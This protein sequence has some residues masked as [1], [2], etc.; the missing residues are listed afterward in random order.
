MIYTGVDG[1]KS[2]SVDFSFLKRDWKISDR[3][4]RRIYVVPSHL[5]FVKLED[6]EVSNLYD[7]RRALALEI[8]ERFGEV[9]WDVKL[10]GKRYY[11]GVVRDFPVP[12]DAFSIE[13]EIFS[14]ARVPRALSLDDCYVLDLG[15]KK[16]TLVRVSEGQLQS[17]RVIL[18]GGD[19]ITQ[20]LAQRE[21]VSFEEAERIKLSEGLKNSNVRDALEKIIASLGRDIKGTILMSGGGSRMLGL[22]ELFDKTIK[23][24]YVSP[25]LNSAFGASLK[26]V[27]RDCS[28]DFIGEELSEKELKRV[29]LAFGSSLLIFLISVSSMNFL[30]DRFV[31]EIREAERKAFKEGFPELPT[32]AVRDQVKSMV[33]SGG[34]EL[35]KDLLKLS[36]K[37]KEGVEIYKLEF[38]DGKLSVVGSTREEK[39][40]TELGAKSLKKT[41][42]GAYEFE[43]E[44]E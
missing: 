26:F 35:T 1:A 29:M 44:I 6:T 40:A 33:T 8:E 39:I 30:G 25:E 18:K 4:G 31:R 24:E 5:S 3:K 42:E 43:V 12:E 28:P 9:L 2:V 15:R 32:I 23:N 27:Y 17:Y 14:L 36:E 37:L 20:Y 19:Y 16:T 34:Y 38:K 11:L 21:G 7:L 10:K 22:R 41:P 13:P